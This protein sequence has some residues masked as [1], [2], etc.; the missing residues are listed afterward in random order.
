MTRQVGEPLCLAV[1]RGGQLVVYRD[2]EVV[3]RFDRDQYPQ[4]IR[5]MAADL[6]LAS[7]APE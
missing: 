7:I 4:I 2:G 3:A 6:T 1:V 5:D